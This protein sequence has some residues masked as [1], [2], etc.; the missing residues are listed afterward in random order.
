MRALVGAAVAVS[1]GSAA[2][3]PALRRPWWHRTSPTADARV[4]ATDT[5]TAGRARPSSRR[6][7]MRVRPGGASARRA[8]PVRLT[9]PLHGVTYHSGPARFAARHV[10]VGDRRLPARA[11]ARRLLGHPRAPRRRRGDSLL[12][13]PPAE[14]ALPHDARSA[15]STT[16][17]SRSTRA[18]SR[19]S[20]GTTL[21]VERD[22][23]GRIGARTCGPGTG[24][25][26]ATPEARELRS[27][28]CEA[29]DAHLFNVELTPDYNWPHRNHFH[30]EVTPQ[31]RWF[32]VH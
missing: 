31:V 22:F 11:R 24:P 9:G 23:H 19:S 6:R 29:A 27:I 20:D 21:Q 4:R 30:L 1:V 7:H 3:S 16:A 18:G 10:A 5:S 15:T 17:R 13:V 12:R 2:P 8:R 28:V 32:L 25:S 14:R 26:P